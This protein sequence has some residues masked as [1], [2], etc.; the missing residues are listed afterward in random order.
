MN[1]DGP[2]IAGWVGMVLLLVAYGGR[3]R[4]HLRAYSILNLLGAAGLTVLTYAQAA[5]PAFA[6]QLIWGSIACRDLLSAGRSQQALNAP[7]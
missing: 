2:Q 7:V 5:W 1:I 4:F 6:L 3:R